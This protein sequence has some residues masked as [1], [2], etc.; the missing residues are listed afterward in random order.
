[1]VL[2]VIVYLIIDVV[3]DKSADTIVNGVDALMECRTNAA[4]VA[5]CAL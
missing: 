3:P 2:T 4:Y 1:M 5:Y